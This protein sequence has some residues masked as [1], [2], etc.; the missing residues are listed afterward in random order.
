MTAIRWAL[1]A[2][3]LAPAALRAQTPADSLSLQVAE[4]QIDAFNRRDLDAFMA[5]YA[6]DAV[7]MEFPSGAV[8]AAGKAAIRERYAGLLRTRPAEAPTVRVEPRVVDG[9]FVLDYERWDAPP[10]QRA[11]AIWMYEIR[12]GLIRRAWTVRM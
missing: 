3:A 6:D 8:I 10:G 7:V 12:N 9:G 1:L 5:L 11:H 2:A 4:R